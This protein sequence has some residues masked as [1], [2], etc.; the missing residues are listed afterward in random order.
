MSEENNSN[1]TKRAGEVD[2]EDSLGPSDQVISLDIPSG[3]HGHTFLMRSALIGAE[4][5]MAAA[6]LIARAHDASAWVVE[7]ATESALEHHLEITC[8]ARLARSSNRMGF[9]ART[10]QSFQDGFGRQT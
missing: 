4:S 1:S 8:E 3:A 9:L 2:P 7:N 5:A 10:R 6:L